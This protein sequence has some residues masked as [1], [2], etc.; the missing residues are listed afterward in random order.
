M[1]VLGVQVGRPNDVNNPRKKVGFG[2]TLEL[3]SSTGLTDCSQLARFFLSAQV[4]GFKSAKERQI[5]AS[6][7]SDAV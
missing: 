1:R 6:L 7:V 3:A 5:A 2:A 4:R